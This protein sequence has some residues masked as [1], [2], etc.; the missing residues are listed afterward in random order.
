[1]HQPTN[2]ATP[3]SSHPAPSTAP[4]RSEPLA[5]PQDTR[6][7]AGPGRSVGRDQSW[8]ATREPVV[9][10]LLIGTKPPKDCVPHQTAA[11]CP[12]TRTRAQARALHPLHPCTKQALAVGSSQTRTRL[13]D[14]TR[15]PTPPTCRPRRSAG[16]SA[17]GVRW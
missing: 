12:K 17:S 1:M 2:R 4:L 14:G 10:E 16:F 15:L 7:V 11:G 13:N 6:L 9:G 3:L 5:R 8:C